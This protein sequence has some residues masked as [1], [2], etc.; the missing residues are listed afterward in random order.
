MNFTSY[1]FLG[2]LAVLTVIYYLIPKKGQWILLLAGSLLFYLA[3]GSEFLIYILAVTFIVYGAAIIIENN[4][5]RQSA[6]LKA[7]KEEL[8]G[9]ERKAYKSRQ[10]KLRKR[11]AAL[12]LLL[13]LG[14]L[15]VV[16]YADFAVE[17]INNFFRVFGRNGE[18]SFLS[19]AL[20]MGISFYTFQAVGYL[21]DVYRG[22]VRAQRNLFRFALFVS[23]FPQLIQGPISRYGDLS[24]TLYQEHS[25]DA[26]Q[27]CFGLQRILWGYFKKLVIADRLLMGVSVIIGNLD[28]Y[29]GA[30]AI[31]GMFFY[32]IELYADFTGGIDIT[33]GIA[34]MLGIT[35]KE[36]F[37]LPYFSKSLKEYWRR[38]HISM[39]TWFKDYVFFPFSTSA[40]MRRISKLLN[41][42]LPLGL[43][44]RL[45]VWLASFVV[46]LSTGI[47][48]GASWNF[49]VWGLFNWLVL[50]AS[51][52]LEPL[53]RRFH[54]R[55]RAGEGFLYKSFMI[56][57]TFLLV[58]VLNLFDCY[59]SVSETFRAL[60][61]MLVARNFN[62]FWDGSLLHIGLSASD[63]RILLF[64]CLLMLFVSLLKRK[65]SVRER[66][67][68]LCYP[69]RF[70]IWY[71]LFLV[72]LLMGI[73]GIGY[74]AGQFI[75]NR[76]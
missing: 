56:V 7:H 43:A 6:Y 9:E 75:Y 76:F 55:F 29:S 40:F 51:E 15:A 19:L 41:R 30:Y 25:F 38:W 27:V 58:C 53:Y 48:H 52:E 63:Y 49:V 8:S 68:R 11:Y 12:C 60:G 42:R 21:I 62:V 44:R 23:F 57:R 47:W 32:T 71:G 16:K 20:P 54:L 4:S 13:V 26:K 3:A 45:P 61:S 2:F 22:T 39:C 1:L 70:A 33:I 37:A 73:Y 64:G 5:D 67:G 59:A 34:Q 72:V 36:N 28:M 10:T 35:V 46:W 50:M 69:C 66:I 31:A 14:I 74:D 17:N 24:Q 65:G 18:L